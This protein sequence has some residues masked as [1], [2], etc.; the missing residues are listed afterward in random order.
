[1]CTRPAVRILLALATLPACVS[2]LCATPPTL[3]TNSPFLPPGFQPP[4][5]S[6]STPEK[7]PPQQRSSY[8]FR[9]VYQIGGQYYF[10]L[11]NLQEQKGQW[12]S[13]ASVEDEALEILD[14]DPETDE[15]VVIIDGESQNLGLIQTSDKS[16]PVQTAPPRQ[17]TAPSRE[18]T[19]QRSNLPVRRRVIRPTSRTGS[20]ASNTSRRPVINRRPAN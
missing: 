6:A 13:D 18:T 1:M 15:L 3:I 17:T 16:M 2:L 11:F 9:G 7:A 12:M 10:H 20:D 5:Q 8:E 14:Y 4:G 19:P